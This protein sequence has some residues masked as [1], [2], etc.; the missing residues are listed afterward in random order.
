MRLLNITLMCAAAAFLASCSVSVP[1]TVTNN[2]M[3]TKTGV[4]TNNCL[5]A[6]VPPE[7]YNAAAQYGVINSGYGN[8]KAVSGGWCFNDKKYSIADAA[9][10]GGISKVATVDLKITN[11]VFFF[12]YELIVTG[13]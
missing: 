9:A 6:P 1:V 8:V 4:A 13:E 11:Y 7:T 2:S 12:K 5:S 3:G 10:N